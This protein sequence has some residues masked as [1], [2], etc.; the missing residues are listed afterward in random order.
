MGTARRFSEER[1]EIRADDLPGGY[2]QLAAV[3]EPVQLG[4][5]FKLCIVGAAQSRQRD[6][7]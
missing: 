3:R 1:L 6:P 4:H 5:P 7:L 2:M